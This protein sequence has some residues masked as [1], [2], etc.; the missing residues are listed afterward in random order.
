MLKWLQG[1]KKQ[2]K[3]TA[4]APA[5]KQ[6]TNT[7]VNKT[8]STPPNTTPTAA[9]NDQLTEHIRIIAADHPEQTIQLLKHWIKD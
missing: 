4:K 5:A 7:T 8:N 3:S 9:T 2:P 6:T 1:D